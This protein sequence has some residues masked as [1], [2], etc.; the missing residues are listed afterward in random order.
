[1]HTRSLLLALA[2]FAA[3]SPDGSTANCG[4]LA[5]PAQ[6]RTAGPRDRDLAPGIVVATTFEELAAL[7]ADPAGPKQIELR[8]LY[9]GDLVVKRPVALR[10][11]RGAVLHGTGNATV[12]TIAANDVDVENVAVRHSGRRGTTEDAAIRA[13]GDRIRLTD[14]RVDDALFGVSLQACRDC[15]L[16]RTHIEGRDG[17]EAN[18]RGDGIKLWESHGSVVRGCVV[19]HVRDVVVW[20]TRRALLEDNVVRGSRYGAHFMYAH[21]SIARRN[22]VEGNVVGIFVMYSQRVE[23]ESNVLAGARGAAG[24]GVGFKDSDDVRIRRNWIV[25]NTTGT[26]LDHSPRTPEQTVLFEGNV[27]ALNDV[28]LRLHGADKGVALHGNAFRD[29]ASAIEVD[30]GGDALACDVRGNHFSDY[31]GYD[32]NGDG[33]GDV[34]YRVNALST[35]LSDA[36]PNLKLFQG[37]VAMQTIDAIA[38]AVPVLESKTLLVDDAPLVRAPEVAAP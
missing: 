4:P 7:V 14:L 21:D 23:V 18:L 9:R 38:H 6:A 26:Y 1:M 12:L 24:M 31:E 34:P 27:F 30:G 37:T 33:V 36:Q 20:Y 35:E 32:L 22:R 17:G 19:A 15:T 2:A 5:V 3:A 11:S 29:N 16:E 25:A 10:G 28:A 13:T 8:G